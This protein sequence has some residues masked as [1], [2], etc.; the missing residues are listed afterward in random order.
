MSSKKEWNEKKELFESMKKDYEEISSKLGTTKSQ[1]LSIQSEHKKIKIDFEKYQKAKA[2]LDSIKSD[3]VKNKIEFQSLKSQTSEAQSKLEERNLLKEEY[4]QLKS[5]IDQAKKELKFTAHQ[6]YSAGK[7]D[8]S[9]QVIEAASAMVASANS[10]LRVS[11][12]EIEVLKL[13]LENE[14]RANEETKKQLEAAK[15]IKKN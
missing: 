12:K 10:K 2:Q 11:Q 1:L 14:R 6:I 4:E 15:S 5:K 9:K 3:I 13:T 8:S 7:K